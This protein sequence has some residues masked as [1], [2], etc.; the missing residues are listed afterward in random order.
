MTHT[1]GRKNKVAK[2]SFSLHRLLLLPKFKG[3]L[4]EI[5][6]GFTRI[7]LFESIHKL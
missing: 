1:K 6:L 7:L 2:M 3:R 5:I 4:S